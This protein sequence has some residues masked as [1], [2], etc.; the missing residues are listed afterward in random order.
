MA[1]IYDWST[2]ASDN[3]TADSG[4]TWSEGQAPSTVNNSARMMMARIA[5]FLEDIGG[6]KSAGG[7]ANALTFTAESGFTSYA[8]GQVIRLRAIATNTGAATLNVNSIGAKAIRTMTPGGETALSGSEIQSGGIYEL[9]YSA[10]INSSVGGWLLVNPS[11]RSVPVGTVADYAGSTAPDGWLLCYGQAVS[12]TTYA[13]LFSAISTTYGSG[14]G[15]TTFNVPDAR[16]RVRG[17][18]DDMGGTSANRLTNQTG[19]LNG[20]TLGATGGSETHTLT[21]GQMPS[22]DH[23]G[24]TNTTGDHTHTY[25]RL[26]TTAGFAG[27]GNSAYTFGTDSTSTSSA[28]SHSHTISSQGGGG[29]HNNVQPTIIF[30]TIIYAGL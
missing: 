1:S 12:R 8:D 25:N 21:V 24:S 18:K 15:S 30:N 27:G 5:E 16:G 4:L 11:Q 22:H 29:A 7:S 28:G 13:A 6:S 20:D 3:A 10:D 26:D 19:G 2:T 17:G 9:I 23:D 14:D